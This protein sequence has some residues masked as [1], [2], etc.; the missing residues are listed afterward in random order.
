[1]RI[2][3]IETAT[4]TCSVALW[5]DGA[6]LGEAAERTTSSHASTLPALVERVLAD[7][8]EKLA[9]GDC[10]A[11]SI[12]P[13]SFTGLRIGLSFAKGLAFSAGLTVVGVPTLDAYALAAA[14]WTGTLCV[15]LDARKQEVYAAVYAREGE[16]VARVGETRAITA[17]RLAAELSGM[18]TAGAL[19]AP[20]S[21]IGD[22]GEAYADVF[23]AIAG[24]VT[25]LPT[26]EHPP[27]AAT[28]ARLAAARLAADGAGDDVVT[29]AP[30]YLRPPE[31]ELRQSVVAPSAATAAAT[32][33]V[34][35]H[36]L[37]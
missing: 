23:C 28:I 24:G 26:T 20:V 32:L 17:A 16:R 22:G 9:R 30:A 35:R 1:M 36:Y 27:R 31:A 15:A 8:G 13:G 29:L 14:G 5:R 25:V 33:P 2:L 4:W 6:V 21:V 18:L 3:A 7:G 11:V 19:D 10:V 37:S 12:G 34:E